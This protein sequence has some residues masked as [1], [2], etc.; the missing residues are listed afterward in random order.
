MET[1]G[2]AD[3]RALRASRCTQES[4]GRKYAYTSRWTTFHDAGQCVNLQSGRSSVGIRWRKENSG[5]ANRWW[6]MGVFAAL[7][8]MCFSSVSLYLFARDP[9]SENEVHQLADP[10]K[11]AFLHSAQ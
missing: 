5:L 11:G 7:I 9:Y 6:P 1:D 4:R 10:A 8:V 2:E 3:G